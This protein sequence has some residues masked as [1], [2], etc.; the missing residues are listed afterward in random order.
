V[1]RSAGHA[2]LQPCAGACPSVSLPVAAQTRHALLAPDHLTR[3]GF[4]TI[5]L[6]AGVETMTAH[7]M[8]WEGGINPRTEQFPQAQV[9]GHGPA[10]LGALRATAG[11]GVAVMAWR[12][13]NSIRIGGPCHLFPAVS[14]PVVVPLQ[15]CL[16]PMGVTSENVAAKFGVDRRT[17][18]CKAA[19]QAQ[20]CCAWQLP[21]LELA[22]MLQRRMQLHCSGPRPVPPFT[23]SA[24]LHL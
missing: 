24:A 8:S 7:P 16:M 18:V 14:S 3:A 11:L 9:G 1:A 4:Y 21:A 19:A 5:G 10:G 13:V 6:A 2:C 17:Q 12:A 20:G 22:G 15:S 23:P